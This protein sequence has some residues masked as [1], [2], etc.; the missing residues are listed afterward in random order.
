MF[1]IFA[2]DSDSALAFN[3][4]TF[5][6]NRLYGCSNL[7]DNLSFPKTLGIYYTIRK[8]QKQEKNSSKRAQYALCFPVNL[9]KSH[10]LFLL[11]SPDNSAFC[12]IIG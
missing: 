7:H 2:N 1:W 6:A 3:D 10:G 12:Q 8:N 5:L 4:L 11:I 9:Y